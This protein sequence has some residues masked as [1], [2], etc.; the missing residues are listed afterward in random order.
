MTTHVDGDTDLNEVVY[1][2]SFIA[3]AHC[4]SLTEGNDGTQDRMLES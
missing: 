4:T 3:L 1:L 2:R